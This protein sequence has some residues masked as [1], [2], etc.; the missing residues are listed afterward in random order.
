MLCDF[1]IK[2]NK[3]VKN[4]KYKKLELISTYKVNAT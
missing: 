4:T 2:A 1:A 3:F